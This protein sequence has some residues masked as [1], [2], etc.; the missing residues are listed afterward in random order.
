MAAPM[1]NL[2]VLGNDLDR[3]PVLAIQPRDQEVY[4]AVSTRLRRS[5]AGRITSRELS[6]ALWPHAAGITVVMQGDRIS[7]LQLSGS[8][9]VATDAPPT[10]GLWRVAAERGRAVVLLMPPDTWDDTVDGP[11][12]LATA[13]R[14]D[15]LAGQRRLLGGLAAIQR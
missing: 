3:W 11:D 5:G 10:T 13:P 7:H 15:A 6:G 2:L 14:I 12:P 1:W 8:K 4:E 9:V